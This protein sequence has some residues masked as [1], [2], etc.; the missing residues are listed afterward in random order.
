METSQTKIV[1]LVSI[2]F[3]FI[4]GT[5]IADETARAQFW[6]ENTKA[7]GQETRNAIV[8]LKGKLGNTETK[9]FYKY[10][11]TWGHYL[12]KELP[13][14]RLFLVVEE[15][16]EKIQKIEFQDYSAGFGLKFFKRLKADLSLSKRESKSVRGQLGL[17]Y[18][19]NYFELES[20]MWTG[21][22][23]NWKVETQLHPLK[24][25]AFYYEIADRGDFTVRSWGIRMEKRVMK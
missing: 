1:L 7:G 6:F 12:R 16:M 14:K 15:E 4:A 24:N 2:L 21:S 11:D 23:T 20:K 9:I 22:Y 17:R 18:Y 25:V 13:I 5:T 19:S 8:E 10:P 3:L